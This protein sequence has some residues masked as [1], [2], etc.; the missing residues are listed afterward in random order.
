MKLDAT[1]VTNKELLKGDEN[2]L[3]KK[4]N[5]DIWQNYS[6]LSPGTLY[7]LMKARLKY[8]FDLTYLRVLLVQE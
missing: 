1:N 6:T 3:L 2:N 5:Y 4:C 8:F 7:D